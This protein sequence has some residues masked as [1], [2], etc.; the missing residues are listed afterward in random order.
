MESMSMQLPLLADAMEWIYWIWLFVKVLIGFSV[1]IFVHELGHFLAAKWVGVRVDRF[2]VGFGPRVFGWRKGEGLTLGKRPEYNAEDL[3]K[4]QYG[5]TDYCFRALPIGGYVKMLGQDDIIINEETGEVKFTDDP[6]SF[7]NKSVGR[8]MIVVSAG[9]IFNLLFAAAALMTVFLIGKE[10]PSPVIGWVHPDSTA[11]G[12]LL[13]GDRILA[14][15][16]RE[17]DSFI[18]V[19]VQTA[20]SDGSMA[21]EIERGGKRLE[22]PIIVE[23]E[24]AALGDVATINID[25]VLTTRRLRAGL[26][27]R[28]LPNLQ[29]GDVITHVGD[30]PVSSALEIAD[31]FAAS[32]GEVLELTVQR[33]VPDSEDEYTTEKVYQRA[34]LAIQPAD[35]PHE[36]EVSSPID[37]AHLLG[38][39]RRRMIGMVQEGSPAERAGLRRGDVVVEWGTIANPTYQEIKDSI[40]KNPGSELTVRV[41]R[42][43]ETKSLTV[44]PEQAFQFFG[45]AEPRVGI[46]FSLR[47]E[48]QRTVVA[49][50]VPDTPFG[51]LNIPRGARLTALAGEPVEDWF[52][53]VRV[54]TE[55]AGESIAVEY[56]TAGNVVRGEVSIPDSLTNTLDLPPGAI[57]WSVDGARTVSITGSDG[58]ERML[59]L[60]NNPAALRTLLQRKIGET[61]TIRYTPSI[62]GEPREK[63]FVVREDNLDP[64]QLRISYV[65]DRIAFEPKTEVISAGGNPITALQMAFNLVRYQVWQVY[66]FLTKIATREI[67][68]SNVAGPVGIFDMAIEQARM[69]IGELLFFMAFLSVNL[70]VINFLPLPVMDGGL[71]VFLIIEKIK[72]KPLSFKT[73]MISTMVGL[74]AIVLVGIF[75]TIQDISRFF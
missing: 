30:R 63:S 10:M 15:N 5:E 12:K 11:Q 23:A 69:G 21:F 20:L 55:H 18:D 13:P 56:E 41:L 4:K 26:P 29:T 45:S 46:D 62:S 47:A 71:M 17:I 1:I 2:A 37:N 51:A 73:Q 59:P 72:G 57:I 66:T 27:V 68:T 14:V 48:E 39:Q 33:P 42:D 8:R 64:W 43:G 31:A 50:V 38:L 52:E 6:R 9:V 16:G 34:V 44:V 53:V 25:P 24:E 61:V 7:T 19:R 67:G 58:R 70:A 36:R 40:V 74:A 49:D 60:A 54:L 35:L 65:F 28:D 22:E 75:V 3:E 32:R